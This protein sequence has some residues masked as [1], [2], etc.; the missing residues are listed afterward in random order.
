MSALFGDDRLAMSND[1]VARLTRPAREAR[2]ERVWMYSALGDPVELTVR[3]HPVSGGRPLV[4]PVAYLT[5][6]YAR[7]LPPAKC[8]DCGHLHT[9]DGCTGD[10]TPSD[11]WAGVTPAVCDCDTRV[12]P[13]A[14]GDTSRPSG[15]APHG[16]GS[17]SPEGPRTRFTPPDKKEINEAD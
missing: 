10:P 3:A 11:L 4:A 5:E 9:P 14:K 13:P 12:L 8:P 6:H 15:V 16:S 17:A 2:V 7:V 1:D